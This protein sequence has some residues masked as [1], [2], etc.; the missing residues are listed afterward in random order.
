MALYLPR[1]LYEILPYA[2][3]VGGLAACLA[4]YRS[5]SP[6]LSNLAFWVGAIGIVGGLMLILRRRS[7]RVDAE[8]YDRHSLDD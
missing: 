1:R 4:S 2:Y 5:S 3:V 8:R 6:L 7:Y